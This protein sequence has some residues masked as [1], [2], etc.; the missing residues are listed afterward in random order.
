MFGMNFP[1]LSRVSCVLLVV[2]ALT[3]LSGCSDN[4]VRTIPVRGRITYGGGPWP[5]AGAIYF[6]P[7]ESTGKTMRPALARFEKDGVF[8]A[9]TFVDGDGLIPGK[10]VM[11]V[12][13]W[14][15]APTLVAGAPEP[16]SYVPVAI[17][18]GTAEGWKLE[19]ADGKDSLELK[20]DVPKT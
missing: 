13:C 10:Y 17:Q 19:V 2:V 4:G 1:W 16:K 20:L 6:T 3:L 11:K 12:E 7:L 15:F 14:E 8:S 5:A 18:T 9:R